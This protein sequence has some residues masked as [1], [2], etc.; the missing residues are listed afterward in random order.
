MFACDEPRIAHMYI[1]IYLSVL[2]T[3]H[4]RTLSSTKT[5]RRQVGGGKRQWPPGLGGGR[6]TGT[7]S[8]ILFHSKHVKAINP[9]G[10]PLLQLWENSSDVI[11]GSILLP[12]AHRKCRETL[13]VL[14]SRG[15]G[16]SR[17]RKSVAKQE[18][19]L[20]SVSQPRYNQPEK[21]T[22]SRHLWCKHP[23]LL[24]DKLT[25]FCGWIIHCGRDST[26]VCLY[27]KCICY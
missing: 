11:R 13:K 26:A 25:C 19:N 6:S 1:Y 18:N 7:R 2:P 17:L 8:I 4:R 3:P 16:G 27:V 20:A 10:C 5:N 9:L 12:A 24:F 14:A 22:G 23:E 15:E 21:K